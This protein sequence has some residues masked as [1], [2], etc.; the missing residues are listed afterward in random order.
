MVYVFLNQATNQAYCI[1]QYFMYTG[2]LKPGTQTGYMYCISDNYA[3]V[4]PHTKSMFM[5]TLVYFNQALKK[6]MVYSCTLKRVTQTRHTVCSFQYFSI[7]RPYFHYDQENI[8]IA[9]H[10]PAHASW[11]ALSQGCPF[12]LFLMHNFTHILI[13][14]GAHNDNE[15]EEGKGRNV[16]RPRK[17]LKISKFSHGSCVTKFKT[18]AQ[19]TWR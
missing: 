5:C 1:S 11:L 17:R 7:P 13:L 8:I 6:G 2:I 10:I 18:M 15:E 19:R 14:S 9:T 3:P 12:P 4:Q 16:N